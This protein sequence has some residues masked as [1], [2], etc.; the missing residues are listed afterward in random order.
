M[1]EEIA[2]T[3]ELHAAESLDKLVQ[4]DEPDL[5]DVWVLEGGNAALVRLEGVLKMLVLL[6][7]RGKIEH[8]LRRDDAQLEHRGVRALRLLERTKRLL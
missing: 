3:F 2:S 6:E 7:E 4:V 5:E 1:L 8:E